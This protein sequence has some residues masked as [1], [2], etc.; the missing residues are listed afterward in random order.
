MDSDNY[1]LFQSDYLLAFKL[2]DRLL[3]SFGK[4]TQES[5]FSDWKLPL[6]T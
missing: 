2:G 3:C 5:N 1:K 6:P 4:Q